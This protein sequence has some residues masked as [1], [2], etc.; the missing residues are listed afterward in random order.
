MKDH[1]VEI[2]IM[3]IE[4]KNGKEK[5]WSKPVQFLFKNNG[6]TNG[7]GGDVPECQELGS[8]IVVERCPFLRD[9]LAQCLDHFVAGDISGCAQLSEL[10]VIDPTGPPPFVLVSLLST[11]KVE[12]QSELDALVRLRSRARTLVLARN[13]DPA[14]ARAAV[15]NGASGYISANASF[16]VFMLAL[17]CVA[18]GSGYISVSCFNEAQR[19]PPGASRSG[20]AGEITGR[21]LEVIQ[22]IRQGKSN[23]VIAYELG[24]C[25]GT[26][27]AH[28]RHIMKKLGSKNRTEVAIKGFEL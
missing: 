19:S 4:H 3:S 13:D 5:T 6:V 22:A 16:D 2:E 10:P 7:H 27:K 26:V 23:K 14:E 15:N 28:V 25:E 20:S 12:T 24:M 8:I 21:E 9:C 17:K 18:A 1:G 11:N